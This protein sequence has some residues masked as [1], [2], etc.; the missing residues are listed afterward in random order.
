M[1]VKRAELYKFQLSDFTACSLGLYSFVWLTAHLHTDA[2]R[3]LCLLS[4]KHHINVS[5][6][7][8]LA[9]Y[10]PS[11][12]LFPTG[13][14]QSWSIWP[15]FQSGQCLEKEALWFELWNS[16][17]GSIPRHRRAIRLAPVK[18]QQLRNSDANWKGLF[19][20]N[21]AT[22]QLTVVKFMFQSSKSD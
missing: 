8:F 4:S 14:E 21:A 6:F 2:I 17:E 12:A 11:A 3:V 13:W 16:L 19:L 20:L 1:W 10:P 22:S 5:L 9:A 7:L 18:R 15:Y